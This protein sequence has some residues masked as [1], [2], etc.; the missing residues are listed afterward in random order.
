MDH[1]E[2]LYRQAQDAEKERRKKEKKEKRAQREKKFWKAFLFTENGKPKSGLL[3]Y[4]FCMS[5]LFLAVYIVAF[6]YLIEWLTPV[7]AGLPTAVSNLL[8]S[9]TVSLVGILIGWLLH[10]VIKD[11]RVIFGTFL[12]LTFY[13]VLVL[14]SLLIMLRGT[15][16][17]GLFLDFYLWFM[18][19]PVLI[20]LAASFGMYKK[21][22]VPPKQQEEPEPWKQYTRRR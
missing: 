18:V 2:E 20:G 12:W 14:V 7:L 6:N 9:L 10:M 21:D 16:T 4:T 22:Y 11:K 1:G 13:L 8:Q 17:I 3:I 5:F 19:I 15:G